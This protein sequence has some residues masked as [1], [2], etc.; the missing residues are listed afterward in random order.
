VPP[1]PLWLVIEGRPNRQHPRPSLKQVGPALGVLI[2]G[3]GVSLVAAVGIR[4]TIEVTEQSRFDE[5]RESLRQAILQRMDVYTSSLRAVQG[6]FLQGPVPPALF[7]AYVDRLGLH[8]RFPGIQAVG[9]ARRV[10]AGEAAAWRIP[11]FPRQG[12]WP[13]GDRPEYFPVSMIE[14]LDWRNRRAL[15]F[16]MY[17]E[18]IR[19][20]AMARARDSGRTTASAKVELVQEVGKHTQPGF[21]I[22]VPVYDTIL[23]PATVSGRRQH[24]IGFVYSPFRAGDLMRHVLADMP[25]FGVTVD[26][27][28]GI[29]TTAAQELFV[30]GRQH[31]P[32]GRPPRGLSDTFVIQVAGQPW[33]V[34]I[35]ATPRFAAD[36]PR[37]LPY[38]V[39]AAGSGLSLLLAWITWAQARGRVAAERMAGDL[40]L[41][42]RSRHN[43]LQQEKAARERAAFLAEASRLL[44]SSLDLRTILDAIAR[45]SVPRIADW[46]LIDRADDD[47][48]AVPLILVHDDA[49]AA[50]AVRLNRTD[51]LQATGDQP[52]VVEGVLAT[53]QSQFLPVLTPE[54]PLFRHDPHTRQIVATYGLRSAI[55]VP[56]TAHGRRIGALTLMTAKSGRTY[57][58]ADLD[59]AE[60]LAGRIAM[61]MDNSRLYEE[62][63][64]A[65][66]QAEEAVRVRDEFLSIA[67][68]ELRTP[69]TSL[70]LHLDTILRRLR[71]QTA[72]GPTWLTDKLEG[73]SRQIERLTDLINE[74]LDVSRITAGRLAI[75][76]EDLD[77]AA[78][79]RD[80]VRRFE[81]EA[82]RV[83]SSVHLLG[84]STLCGRLDRLR[85]EQIVTNLLS[86]ALKYGAGQPVEI[87]LD[88]V[89]DMARLTVTDHGIGIDPADQARIFERFERL[90]SVRHYGG[91]GLGLWIVRRVVEAHGGSITV[92][93]A[94]G[95]GATFTVILPLQPPAPAEAA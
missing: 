42:E 11:D 9:F 95:Q 89:Q 69:I 60:S 7:R 16:D 80:I 41:S 29:E 20:V 45:L 18:P 35:G 92:A 52:T 13:A 46:C 6:L 31:V 64:A 88:Q 4:R 81:V 56:L 47:G 75:E 3:L 5:A 15:G 37:Q 83:G 59:L 53:G 94:S 73:L 30:S 65:R 62:A 43:L 76:P 68:H 91:F 26:V 72:Q 74:M 12:L 70:H 33:T 40:R 84:E 51:R 90:V 58:P 44:S 17:A 85:L 32:A 63:L 39:L 71:R 28:D 38:Y 23:V 93:S 54:L 48:G 67:S 1:T 77:V 34:R 50:R 49:E 61:A 87:R 22:Y 8:R 21:N 57:G 86:N 82:S 10:R 27:Y 19:Q 79:L 66:R 36:L 2:I 55:V 78:C 25:D 14:P 24:L